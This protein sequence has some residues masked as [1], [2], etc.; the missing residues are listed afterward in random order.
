[1]N[2]PQG[3]TTYGSGVNQQRKVGI[4]T[5]RN[6]NAQRANSDGLNSGLGTH[7]PSSSKGDGYNNDAEMRRT[8]NSRTSTHPVSSLGRSEGLVGPP[9]ARADFRKFKDG[10]QESLDRYEFLK[11]MGA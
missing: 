5:R 10:N 9:K 7:P 8:S 1:M 2:G 4:P 6:I 11:L 3:G